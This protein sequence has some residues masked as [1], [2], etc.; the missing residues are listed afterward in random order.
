MIIN[1]K[2]LRHE[3]RSKDEKVSSLMKKLSK[4]LKIN[5]LVVTRGSSGC[6]LI[7]RKNNKFYY[8]KAYTSKTIDKMGA[9]DTMLSVLAIC[10]FKK[11]DLNLSLLISS[12][13]AAQSVNII[14]NKS[15][16]NK[17]LLLKDLEHFLV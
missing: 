6:V 4:N 1:E 15:S 9:G 11:I 16:I 5:Y 2:E 12:L 8:S 17:S 7:D 3:M 13:C 14:G 10:I